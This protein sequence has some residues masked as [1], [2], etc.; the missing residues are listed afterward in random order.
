MK[1]GGPRGFIKAA[2]S[3]TN[4][5]LDPK[6]P[7]NQVPGEQGGEQGSGEQETLAARYRRLSGQLARAWALCSRSE[8]VQVLRPEITF[9]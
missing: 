7:G 8:A 5:L 6:T 9:Y 2:T 3:A 4:Y 1:A